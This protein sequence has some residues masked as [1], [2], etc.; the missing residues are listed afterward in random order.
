MLKELL[1]DRRK[2][3]VLLGLFGVVLFCVLR[4]LLLGADTDA[5]TGAFQ[6]SY[7]LIALL[8]VFLI[9]TAV[10][11]FRFRE[12]CAPFSP[13]Q[14]AAPALAAALA[15]AVILVCSL[16]ELFV[17]VGEGIAPAPMQEVTNT[18][19]GAC[20]WGAFLSG[21]VGGGALLVHGVRMLGGRKATPVLQ[22]AL[23][24]PVFWLCFRLARYLLSYLSAMSMAQTFYDYAMM[25]LQL[26]FMYHFVCYMGGVG[27][28]AE[29]WLMLS[30]LGAAVC[31]LSN[32]VTRLFAF[33][34]NNSSAFAA[35]QLAGFA[36]AAVGLL[37]LVM[38]VS[39]WNTPSAGGTSALERALQ[40]E[41]PDES[42]ED[43]D[44]TV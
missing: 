1:K 38:A 42:P 15:G 35:S 10:L 9:G 19:D 32:V 17:F 24:L 31:S 33:L 18:V 30:T 43:G 41:T 13:Q 28:T 16:F 21:T 27:K 12:P 20:L 26:I 44:E 3:A 2:C 4:V 29:R 40:G 23:I 39:L 7:G 22:A 37:A 11:L 14:A 25:T 5:Q 6:A 36:D 8:V 34:D